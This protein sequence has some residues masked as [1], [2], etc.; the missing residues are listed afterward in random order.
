MSFFRKIAQILPQDKVARIFSGFVGIM[1]I[2]IIGS[3]VVISIPD[4][5][6]QLSKSIGYA[7]ISYE[8]LQ[9]GK[10]EPPP[11]N[12]DIK[13]RVSKS[14]NQN[15]SNDSTTK[16]YAKTGDK[17]YL[18]WDA[19]ETFSPTKNPN[20]DENGKT[21]ADVYPGKTEGQWIGC[22]PRPLTKTATINEKWKKGISENG[23]NIKW[24][25]YQDSSG[26]LV[27]HWWES[28]VV[29]GKTVHSVDSI[30]N[31][32]GGFAVTIT[33]KLKL[34][35][36]PPAKESFGLHCVKYKSKSSLNVDHIYVA[37]SIYLSKD[38]NPPPPPPTIAQ[39]KIDIINESYPDDGSHPLY[40]NVTNMKA[41]A[42]CEKVTSYLATYGVSFE[43]PSVGFSWN[44]S[45]KSLL[46]ND[47]TFQIV[48]SNDRY[49]G[50]FNSYYNVT[51]GGSGNSANQ[52]K[53]SGSGS[54]F[55]GTETSNTG[56]GWSL[57]SPFYGD[58]KP[59]LTNT[60]ANDINDV[61]GVGT[62]NTPASGHYYWKVLTYSSN[63][64]GDWVE[65]PSF[66]V[67]C[68]YNPPKAANITIQAKDPGVFTPKKPVTVPFSV[69][70]FPLPSITAKSLKCDTVNPIISFQWGSPV[71][72]TPRGYSN[73][74]SLQISTDKKFSSVGTPFIA[75]SGLT[76]WVWSG[77]NQAMGSL[78]GD[79][80]PFTDGDQNQLEKGKKYY[81]R[82][83]YHLGKY[84]GTGPSGFNWGYKEGTNPI[85]L[86][87]DIE[88][89]SET[90]PPGLP[91][92][93][94]INEGS[95]EKEGLTEEEITFINSNL[96]LF[97]AFVEF[98]KNY[99]R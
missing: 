63:G 64:V 13:F 83:S 53:I 85:T 98:W 67:N 42:N 28:N 78:K 2:G 4:V 90:T 97:R 75:N 24:S 81:Y 84:A 60:K 58:A 34:V 21:K 40:Q 9:L 29:T 48:V 96:D 74:Y 76:Q 69:E 39:E 12:N 66:N 93:D 33:K 25:G 10:Y 62:Q 94:E 88:P 17:V 37:V 68:D 70:N 59:M 52:Y 57:W 77:G 36:S 82:Y 87:E 89:S 95:G 65:G 54:S 15:S 32:K 91:D 43:R 50:T 30:K 18:Y 1:L 20:I 51:L 41:S 16:I 92:E 19:D 5:R 73:A 56:I 7:P 71:P 44:S 26:N 35:N 22:G 31:P 55:A 3:V 14:P 80:D 79:V 45:T 11:F 72:K 99:V 27:K 38:G 23:S 46:P 61:G 8:S 6:T 47:T 49:F 86:C